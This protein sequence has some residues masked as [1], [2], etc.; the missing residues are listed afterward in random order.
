MIL[1]IY[2]FAKQNFNIVGRVF[3]QFSDSLSESLFFKKKNTLL[4]ITHIHPLSTLPYLTS[5]PPLQPNPNTFAPNPAF[6]FTGTFI[7]PSERV[8]LVIG[9]GGETIR[10]IQT[11]CHARIIIEQE[12]NPVDGTKVITIQGPSTEWVEYTKQM[13]A[14][15]TTPYGEMG[16]R[17]GGAGGSHG[18]AGSFDRIGSGNGGLGGYGDVGYGGAPAFDPSTAAGGAGA[19]PGFDQEQYAG[20]LLILE[21]DFDWSFIVDHDDVN[22]SYC[23]DLRNHHFLLSPSSLTLFPNTYSSIINIRMLQYVYSSIRY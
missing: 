13:I 12:V 21:W 16:G 3:Y 20:N 7:I 11:T 5:L 10:E 4:R 15:K 18:R 2:C 22:I 8:G 14:Q 9:R 23:D 17:P 19:P 6:A 1:G